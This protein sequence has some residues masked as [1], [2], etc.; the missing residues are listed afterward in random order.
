MIG[1]GLQEIIILGIC[2]LP[3]LAG[4][5]FFVFLALSKG[6]SSRQ[7]FTPRDE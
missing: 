7:D 5:A 1:I 4:L 3:L 2:G 6:K